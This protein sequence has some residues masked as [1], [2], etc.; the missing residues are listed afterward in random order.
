MAALQ[1]KTP[2]RALMQLN[3]Q[4]CNKKFKGLLSWRT[5]PCGNDRRWTRCCPQINERSRFLC[6]STTKKSLTI[7]AARGGGGA[8]NSVPKAV[9]KSA[10]KIGGN[11]PTKSVSWRARLLVASL[12]SAGGLAAACER[13][14]RD[15]EWREAL[16]NGMGTKLKYAADSAQCMAEHGPPALAKKGKE[17]KESLSAFKVTNGVPL[18]EIFDLQ[19]VVDR[20]RSFWNDRLQIGSLGN[21]VVQESN[22]TVQSA[23]LSS[24]QPSAL[25]L[26]V[27]LASDSQKELEEC[28]SIAASSAIK[29]KSDVALGFSD[30]IW[31]AV[32]RKVPAGI[33][34]HD[35][36]L[37]SRRGQNAKIK[38]ELP[39][40]GGDLFLHVKASNQGECFQAARALLESLP[41]E[42]IA[43]A[44]DIY[45]FSY[46]GGQDLL[47]FPMCGSSET[48]NKTKKE[49]SQRA[50]LPTTGGSYALAQL[51]RH[52]LYEF[53]D[54]SQRGQELVV[55]K[56]RQGKYLCE[57]MVDLASRPDQL[58]VALE[59]GTLPSD[60]HVARVIGCDPD[61]KRLGVVSHA[62]PCGS[63]A[64]GPLT[65]DN[66]HEPGM[67]Y[68]AYSNDPVVFSYMLNRMAGL[69]V[70]EKGQ[71]QMVDGVMRFSQCLRGQIYYIP[72]QQ[73]LQ[74]L[75]ADAVHYTNEH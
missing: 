15:T 13:A 1:L 51:W 62:M 71:R 4:Q 52:S 19:A 74:A 46:N 53:S 28:A 21:A 2:L 25:F 72:S 54:L 67:F 18:P 23:V 75:A 58:A 29:I 40:T 64:P 47:G 33:P 7:T 56:N 69:P 37:H 73:Q 12:V 8:V 22:G 17:M 63:L 70:R 45:G 26:T 9:A 32:H 39:A 16:P 31:A 10:T 5:Q 48:A 6:T 68:L 41:E 66:I 24:T 3:H 65:R 14:Q 35:F 61:S 50:V 44:E 59:S 11:Q 38:V 30:R 43:D 27:H 57:K 34:L 55:G 49:L 60:A 42:A 36:S 20:V